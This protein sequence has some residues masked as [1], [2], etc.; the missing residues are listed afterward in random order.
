MKKLSLN[1]NKFSDKSYLKFWIFVHAAVVLFFTATL[2]FCRGSLKIDADLFNMLPKSFAGKSLEKADEKMLEL[3]A[4][5]VI[6]LVSNAD[7]QKAKSVASKVYDSLK[8]SR[9]FNDL[10][11][12][13]DSSSMMKV[14]DYVF[15][16]R[17]NLL[18]KDQIKKI[19][20]GGEA[21]FAEEALAK[22]FSPFTMM[23]L[24]NLDRDPFMLAETGLENYMDA[25]QSSGTAMSLKEDV[26]AARYDDAWYVM[27]RGSLTKEGS[28]LA[29]KK[30]G[31][32]EIYNVC[33]PLE[34]DGT[35]FVFT[36][37]SF[38]SHKSSNAAAREI[39]LISS[40]SIGVVVLILFV[41]FSSFVP[42]VFSVGSIFVSIATA[43]MMTMAVFHKL[44]VLT[45]IFGT[46]LIGSC[47]DYS[48]H[49]FINWKANHN[50]TSGREIREYLFSGLSLSLVSTEICFAILLFAP[51][52]LLKQMS[53]FSLTGILSSFLT[54]LCVYPFVKLPASHER[55]VH[56]TRLVNVPDWYNRRTVGRIAVSIM[57][58]FSV[59]CIVK[60]F[61]HSKIQNNLSELY[62]KEGRVL[63][64]QIEA[65]RVLKYSPSSWFVLCGEDSDSLL[66]K[67]EQF[68][69]KINE[70]D[71]EAG[72]MCTSAFVPSRKRQMES[73]K[74]SEKLFEIAEIQYEMLGYESDAFQQMSSDFNSSENA[75][76]TVDNIPD[77]MQKSI[78]S[79]WLGE[80][81]GKFYSVIMP[82]QTKD[83]DSF[84]ALASQDND[85]FYVSK[86]SDIS[87]D[88]DQLTVMILKFFSVAYV[89]I[90][91]VLKFFYSWKQSFKIISIPLLI[92]L[93]VAA[94]F[95]LAKIHLEFFSITGIILVLGL[96]LDYVIYMVEA[97]KR[98][99]RSD[100][101]RLEP[102]AILLS[103]ATTSVSFGT[104]SLSSFRPV[105]L[106]G[107]AIFIGLFTAYFVSFFY[108]REKKN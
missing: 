64:D 79:V 56:A 2:L 71:S 45:L 35:R 18:N 62:K 52:N 81:D 24:D 80:I 102:F 59:I 84:R 37:T 103:F 13:Q 101:S 9:N 98:G 106:M 72:L 8:D 89:L 40:I 93:M 49:Y 86:M 90:F 20:N 94:I 7:F 38:H 46:S 32:S 22:A 53:V 85:I 60:G 105:H 33:L 66:Y 14:A 26:L 92:I 25:I 55:K 77:F 67:E 96:G 29:S 21:E 17:F 31:I 76:I 43:F 50:L 95:S 1:L 19:E 83:E 10:S 63:D 91:V 41:V 57:F 12:Y 47:I 58:V 3:T 61:E 23:P 36:G 75:F 100:F 5:N 70:I 108:E 99:D 107:L 68:C 11:L 48:L 65:T 6:I 15:E 27:I 28:A 42:I 87:R 16:N 73:R 69:R 97:E 82:S 78:A 88:M 4:Q 44:H 54:V 39:T 30:N 104:L 74:A 34:K 51:F